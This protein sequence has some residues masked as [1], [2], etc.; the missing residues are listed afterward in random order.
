MDPFA[1]AHLSELLSAARQGPPVPG[2]APAEYKRTTFIAFNAALN[3]LKGVGAI[4]DEETVEWSDRMLVALG[5]Q[6]REPEPTVPGVVRARLI[7]FGDE[8]RP[9][10]PPDPPPLSRFLALVPANQPDRPLDYG[11]RAQILGIELYTHKVTVNWRLAPLPDY[12]AV[13]AAEL[14]AQ[15]P[16]LEGLSDDFKKILRDKLVHQLQMRRQFV[17]LVDDVGTEYRSMG[18]GSG[19]GGNERRGNS[20]FAPAVPDEARRLTVRWD[21]LRFDID[22]PPDRKPL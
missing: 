8:D 2:V 20:D 13:F 21:E 7:S 17:G 12:E 16:D 4:S 5:G 1:Q 10:R 6:P 22:L 9:R 18:G 19:G 11:G 14:A 15:E 3:A